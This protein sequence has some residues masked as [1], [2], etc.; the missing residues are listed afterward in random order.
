M[1]FQV[2]QFRDALKAPGWLSQFDVA[3]IRKIADE[4]N[5]E[6]FQEYLSCSIGDAKRILG[7]WEIAQVPIWN[8]EI[9]KRFFNAKIY[10]DRELV[11]ARIDE[12]INAGRIA[13][14]CTPVEGLQWLESENILM[15]MLPQ[16]VRANLRLHGTP[17]APATAP[18]SGW[19]I[20]EPQRF[21]GYTEPLYRLLKDAHSKGLAKP[22]VR[23]ILDRWKAA[24]PEQVAKVFPGEGLDYYTADF[25]NTKHANL[26]AI[27][28][29]I[30]RLTAKSPL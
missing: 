22:G 25:E 27:R 3:R 13:A 30:D 29:A 14:P 7:F 28:A 9:L 18:A 20:T 12:A 16:W 23:E 8:A 11:A 21:Q 4:A 6:E 17:N 15:G 1:K 10:A 24:L 26:K 5:E 2:R 19:A